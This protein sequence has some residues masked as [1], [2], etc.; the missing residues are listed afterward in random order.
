M[1]R[2][3]EF[4]RDEALNAALG[5]FRRKG[6]AATSTDDLRLA[7]GIGRQSFYDTFKGK[8]DAYLEALR[9]YNSDRILGYFEI[10][11]KSDSPLKAIQDMLVSIALEHPQER[12]LACLGVASVCEFGTSDADVRSI[13]DASSAALQS[14]LEKLVTEGKA[15]KKIR[16]SLDPATTARYLQST[17]A[18]LRVTAKAGA[19]R[20]ALRAI[21]TIAVDGLKPQ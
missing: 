20:E 18:G 16:S 17:L 2:P 8:K 1:A 14:V 4:D 13:N 7:M 9:K 15:R 3:K 10:F 19:S 21:A 6:F 12:T 11:R 5:V